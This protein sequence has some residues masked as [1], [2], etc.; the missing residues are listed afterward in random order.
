[1]RAGG[2]HLTIKEMPPDDRPRERLARLGPQALSGSELLAILLRTGTRSE[3]ALDVA[4]QILGGGDGEASG[5][6]GLARAQVAD[7]AGKRGVGMAKACQIVAAVEIGR[8]IAGS[9]EQRPVIKSPG[10]ASLLVMESMR[11]LEQEQFRVILLN[12]KN[13]VLGVEIVFVGGLASSPVHPREIFKSAI[14]K[15]AA[16]VI[17]VHNHPSGDPA[18][19]RE[20]VEVTQRLSEAGKL[21]GIEVLDHLVIGDNRYVSFREKGIA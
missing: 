5:L 7:L 20:D 17:L 8:R 21:L 14:R 19:S 15:S 2:Y 6:H 9:A 1:M 4:R 12:T 18:P 11:H 16:G 13:Q 10:D 3:T